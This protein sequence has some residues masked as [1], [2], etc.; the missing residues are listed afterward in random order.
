MLADLIIVYYIE[1]ANPEWQGRKDDGVWL[2]DEGWHAG[3][4][5]LPGRRYWK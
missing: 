5:V 1:R 3:S 2:T 4:L